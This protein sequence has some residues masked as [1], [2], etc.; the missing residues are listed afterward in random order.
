MLL[1]TEYS[2]RLELYNRGLTDLEIGMR[3]GVCETTICAW[4]HVNGLPPNGR[5][6]LVLPN[7]SYRHKYY[8]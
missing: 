5:P 4:R 6:K 3:C 2:R 1:D 8:F 7:V